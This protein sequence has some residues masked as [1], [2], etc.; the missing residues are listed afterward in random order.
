MQP[1]EMQKVQPVTPPTAKKAPGN[2]VKKI[3][4]DEYF[5]INDLDR[6]SNKKK[7][8]MRTFDFSLKSIL[9]AYGYTPRGYINPMIDKIGEK[10]YLYRIP[11]EVFERFKHILL[12]KD[13]LIKFIYR[14]K[15]GDF[16]KTAKTSDKCA[17]CGSKTKFDS[18]V[19]GYQKHCSVNCAQKNPETKQNI[20]NA[21]SEK[22]GEGIINVFQTEEVKAKLRKT[23]LEKYGHE[24]SSCSPVIK[25]KIEATTMLNYGVK[26][27]FESEVI[28]QKI[29]N[30]NMK[31]LGVPYPMS[32]KEILA[33]MIKT[34]T[35]NGNWYN[36]EKNA[37]FNLYK[38]V[39]LRYTE[40]N[41]HLV[42]DIEKRSYDFHLDHKFSISKGF[43]EN[44]PPYII[45][46]HHNLEIISRIDNIRK[47][48][49]CSV[50]SEELF[51]KVFND[52]ISGGVA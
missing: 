37:D 2:K 27:P 3:A 14:M 39:V 10:F 16:Y 42:K 6:L 4:E 5:S 46:S 30:T 19:A 24:Y 18:L 31:K 12:N 50:S 25:A 29:R 38:R 9:T 1:D 23:N 7:Y 43:K 52:E 17:F 15:I 47:N 21:V 13:K 8:R 41:L 36:Y 20:I 48:F 28:K 11:V 26:N 44:I 45:G 22:Y 32:S 33:K 51:E 40:K 35:E 49:H 34:N